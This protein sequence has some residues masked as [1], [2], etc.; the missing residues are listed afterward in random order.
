MLVAQ[1]TAVSQGR[2]VTRM[3]RFAMLMLGVVVSA[4]AWAGVPQLITE[5]GR[6]LDATG[7][8]VTG[9]VSLAFSIYDVPTGGT[10]LWTE[11]QSA[12]LDDGYFVLQLG[13]VTA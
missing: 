7:A 6:L 9:T 4:R 2:S 1:R 5:Q 3:G 10:A 12:T 13:S 8:P 11:T